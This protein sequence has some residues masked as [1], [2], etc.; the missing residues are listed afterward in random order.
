MKQLRPNETRAKTAILLIWIVLGLDVIS[1]ISSY[2]QADLL[3]RIAM[4]EII[5]PK[6]A[7]ANDIRESIIGILYLI[8]YVTSGITFIMWFRRAYYNLHQK[9]SNLSYGEGW[10][11]GSWFVP[12][13]NLFRPF[14]IMS[15]LYKK[16]QNYLVEKE[17]VNVKK[18]Y[19]ALLAVWWILWIVSGFIGN[20]EFQTSRNAETIDSLIFMTNVSLFSSVFGIP[21]AIVTVKVIKDYAE[22]EPLLLKADQE[23]EILTNSF[24]IG[25]SETLLDD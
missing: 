2:F 22:M 25:D 13:L 19:T 6:V 7:D 10:A 3:N 12:I 1:A 4:G 17:V 15:E 21:L 14:Q 24:E 5:S 16:T 8:V 18:S 9:V 20:F 11:A 23:E